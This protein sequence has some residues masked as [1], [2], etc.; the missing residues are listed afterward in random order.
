[1]MMV[2]QL[3]DLEFLVSVKINYFPKEDVDLLKF[4]ER[5]KY[6]SDFTENINRIFINEITFKSA[7]QSR[8]EQ[9]CTCVSNI[10]N[11]VIFTT[12][13]HIYVQNVNS[14]LQKHKMRP[15]KMV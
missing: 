5:N 9:Y 12:F 10:S 1:M 3:L 8:I 2:L 7:H 15:V 4:S 14:M 6:H 11:I 13:K